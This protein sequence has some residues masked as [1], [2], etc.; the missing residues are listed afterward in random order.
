MAFDL[1]VA[2]A[3]PR[4]LVARTR[5]LSGSTKRD[6]HKGA[7]GR[8]DA[9]LRPKVMPDVLEVLTKLDQCGDTLPVELGVLGKDLV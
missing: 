3:V 2:S 5:A 9:V 1:I 7:E 8:L 4:N 6:R